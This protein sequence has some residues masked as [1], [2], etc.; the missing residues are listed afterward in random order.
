[1]KK[2]LRLADRQELR[3]VVGRNTD[4]MKKELRR[5]LSMTLIGVTEETLT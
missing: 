3:R 1:M 2:E 4:L 5:L